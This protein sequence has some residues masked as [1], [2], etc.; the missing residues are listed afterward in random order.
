[1][2]ISQG[3][4]NAI[5]IGTLCSVSYLAVYFARNILSAVTPQMI[6]ESGFTESYIGQVSSLYFLFYA[7]GQLINGAIGDRIKARYM[8]SFG[9]LLAGVSNLVFAAVAA[10]PFAAKLAY[11]MTGFFLSMIYGPMTKVVAE[12]TEPIYATRCSLGYTFAS[13]F[14]SPLAGVMAAVLTWQSVFLVSSIALGI[15]AVASFGFFL[16]FEKK[17]LV[18]YGQ[19]KREKSKGL[20]GVRVLVRHRIIRFSLISIITGIIRTAVVFWM[21]TY[22]SQHLGFDADSAA[23]IFTVATFVISF[24][25]FV[26]IF[27]YERLKH[28]MDLTIRLMFASSALFF[29]L[30][31]FIKQPIV[32]VSLMVLAVMAS[33][34]AGT[35]LYSRYCPGLRD[36]GMV[37]SATGFLDCLSYLAAAVTSTL[38]ANAVSTIGWGSL[39]LVWMGIELVGVLVMIPFGK[40]R[41]HTKDVATQT[42]A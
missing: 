8:I 38:F 26:A 20:D 18:R 33:N 11:G 19:Y 34:G 30:V 1:M 32:N 14:G 28:N 12:N 39:I 10:T 36:T 16:Y 37:S 2:K 27:V 9:L 31:F 7:L 21:P 35:M 25:T 13:F 42:E 17:G 3:A 22:I 6:A 23:M 40:H 5:F 41:N 4:K 24:T 29:L 15:M